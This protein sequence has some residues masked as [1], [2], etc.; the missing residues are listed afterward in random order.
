MTVDEFARKLYASLRV[1]SDALSKKVRDGKSEGF[2]AL[3]D[4]TM[5]ATLDKVATSVLEASIE[6]IGKRK[7]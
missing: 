2:Q 5:C 4:A 1:E 3:V 6:H 7:I